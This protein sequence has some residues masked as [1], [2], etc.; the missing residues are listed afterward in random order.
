MAVT[1]NALTTGVG[2]LQTTGDTSGAIQLQT[3]GTATVTVDA[4]GNVGIGTA[5][6]AY[7]L[8]TFQTGGPSISGLFQTDQ[9]ASYISFRNTTNASN[10]STR[11]GAE[12]NDISFLTASTERLRIGSNGEIGLSGASYGTSGQFLKSNGSGAAATWGTVAASGALLN[13][14]YFT[15]AGTAT[16]TPTSGT[17]SVIV[18]V[19]G[20][21]GGG[22]G[23]TDA[24]AA[25]AGT[26]GT[27]SFGALVSATGGTGGGSGTGGNGG[28]GS[29]GDINVSGIPGIGI[30]WTGAAASL[31]TPYTSTFIGTIGAGGKGGFSRTGVTSTGGSGG[32]AGYARKK[33]TSSFSGVTVTVGAAGTVG[34]ATF[35]T[36][37]FAGAV[38]VYEYS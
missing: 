33:I 24:S 27:S 32:S 37:G 11:V 17:N 3:N 12:G 26:G 18:E 7:R 9:T 28:S 38:I 15:T 25:T 36:A 29:S 4:S 13:I 30:S 14:Q 5:S 6:P 16:Y 8:Q 22:T 1:L 20:G 10:S 2:G 35:G 31:N 34:T 23:A 21:G 19:I